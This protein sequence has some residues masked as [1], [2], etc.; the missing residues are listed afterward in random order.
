MTILKHIPDAKIIS[1]PMSD[2][3]EGMTDCY[4]R[5]CGGHR[6]TVKVSGPFEDKI[7]ASYGVLSDGTAVIEMAECVGLPLVGENKNPLCASTFGVGEMILHAAMN[8]VRKI[9]L[10]IG[11]SATNDCGIGMAS[12]LGY[13]F[14]DKDDHKVQPFAHN[15]GKIRKIHLPNSLPEVRIIGACDVDNPLY[16]PI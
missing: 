9:I 3:G 8:G 1:L 13:V 5:L 7:D 16:G 6:V 14:V 11:G 12:A 2:G 4:I 15:M 10:G